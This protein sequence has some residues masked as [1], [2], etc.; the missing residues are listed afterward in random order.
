MSRVLIKNA[1]VITLDG[2]DEVLRGTDIAIADGIIEAVGTAP[3]DF[4]PD[5]VLD[6]TDQVVMPGFFNAHTHA[7]MT[8]V[9]GWAEDLPLDRWFNERIWVAESA[10]TEEDVYWGAAL[11]AAE[12]IR[13]GTVGFADHY[14][15]M[16]RVAEVVE[17]SGLR[18]TLAWCV[19]GLGAEQEIGGTTLEMTV[20]FVQ[21]WQGAGDGRIRTVLGPHS[22]YVCPA[23]FLARVAEKAAELG[24][25]VHLHVA[26]SKEQVENSLGQHGRT[27]IAHLAHLGIFDVP[28]IAAHSIYVNDEDLSILAA[29]GVSVAS[30]TG[31]YMK[32]GM[33]VPRLPEMLSRGINVALGTDGTA[34]N[35]NLDMLEEARLAALMHKNAHQDPQL[36]PGDLVLRLATQNSARAMGFPRSGV[37]APGYAADLVVFDFHQPHLRPRHNLI[38]NVIYAAQAGDIRHLMVAGRWLM[39][40]RELLTLDE[41]RIMYEAERRAWRMVGEEL[42][43]VREYKG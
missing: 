9:R 10:L 14:F 24:V 28:A 21:R 2:P 43:V 40:D 30:C 31:C 25:G 35:N 5:E 16:D 3:A 6:A 36:L 39:R 1:D 38:A 37:I 11:A 22:P 17:Q 13:S 12:M 41:E 20:D 19:F 4:V 32:L 8:L 34:S 42:H 18:A 27:P 29:K 26:E 7:P 33:G 23:D 15:W